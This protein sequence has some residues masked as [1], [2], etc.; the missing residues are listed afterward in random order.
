ML[1]LASE[2]QY[3]K[4]V[5]PARARILAA[6]GIL[7]VE[8]LLYYV[9]RRYED[10]RHPRTAAEVQ[11]GETATVVGV[12]R[13]VRA[14]QTRRRG[15]NI[16][17]VELSEGVRRL[18]CRWF[19]SDYLKKI[20]AEGQ[21]LALYGQVEEDSSPGSWRGTDLQMVHPQYEILSGEEAGPGG[22][23]LEV[24]RIVPIYET[25]GSGRLTSRFFRRLVYSVLDQL[26]T[27]D[28]PLP[29][30]VRQELGLPHRWEALAKTHFPDPDSDPAALAS[31]RSAHQFRLIFEEFFFL[32]TGAAV[33][34]RRA[35]TAPGIAFQ[36]TDAVR[37]KIKSILPFH[38]TE[39]QKRV[40]KEIAADMTAPHPMNRLLQGDVGSGKTIVALQ[41]AVI[42]IEN[43]C[44]VA[45]MA[46]TE[47]LAVQHFLYFR[48]LLGQSGY[49]VALLTSA[50]TPGEKT[51]LKRLIREGMVH[52]TIGTHALIEEDVEFRALGLVVVDEQ[53]RFGVLQRLRLMQK[54]RWPDVLVMTAT[55]IPR[56]LALTLYGELEVSV[57]DQ[58]PPGRQPIATRHVSDSRAA[59]VYEFVR[60]Q[61]ASGRQ[62]YIVYPLVEESEKADL[63][64]AME[65]HDRLSRDTFPEFRVG[66]LHG[67]LPADQKDGV[68]SEFKAGQIQVLVATT[69]V[70]VG[71]D[72]PNAAVMVIEHAE[73][74]GLLQLHQLRGRVGRGARKSYCI[75]VSSGPLT[76]EARARLGVLTRTQDGFEIAETDLSLRGPGEFFGTR[77]SGMPAFRIADLVRDRDVLELARREATKL[78]DQTPPGPE[79]AELVRYVREHW[80]RRYGLVMVG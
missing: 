39:A 10:R 38:P 67:R 14:Y 40:L 75:L 36:I 35:R 50:A 12:V 27:V 26:G 33:K 16:F 56:T 24:E 4:S 59:E 42:A 25:A 13:A 30:C 58:M 46:P 20:L 68:M 19:N 11:P 74:F 8:D 34:R 1:T 29:A 69:V 55:P 18:R 77:Q 65:M 47:I 61:V 60:K 53:H 7:T 52:I 66:L 64:S 70:E 54:G 15:L 28:D 62:A 5:G 48:R 22:A 43:G 2:V 76:D 51:K 72:V 9:P 31:F 80:S 57:I 44:Q 78:V 45:V 21:I 6:K 73:R 41:A 71:V 79:T 32:Q 63:K 23:S 37:E 49:Q 17:E 3:I